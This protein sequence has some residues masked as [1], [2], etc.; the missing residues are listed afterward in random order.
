MS[1]DRLGL[2]A[3]L[4]ELLRCPEPHHGELEI[5]RQRSALV[6]VVC[7]NAYPVRDGIPVM[8]RGDVLPES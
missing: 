5:D 2:D 4:L 7:G 3:V 8:L 6:C 1:E